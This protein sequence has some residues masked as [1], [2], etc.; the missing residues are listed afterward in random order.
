MVHCAAFGFTS[1]GQNCEKNKNYDI[2]LLLKIYINI[3]IL[4]FIVISKIFAW[5]FIRNSLK[6]RLKIIFLGDRRGRRREVQQKWPPT[7][8]KERNEKGSFYNRAS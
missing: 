7:G 2:T 5:I 8:F 1:N 6:N 4:D 3:F